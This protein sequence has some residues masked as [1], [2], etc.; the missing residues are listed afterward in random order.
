MIRQ[1]VHSHNF[2]IHPRLMLLQV[3]NFI[4]NN[5]CIKFQKLM[6]LGAKQIIQTYLFIKRQN[7]HIQLDAWDSV[8]RTFYSQLQGPM[9][10]LRTKVKDSFPGH[11]FLLSDRKINL[12]ITLYIH[13]KM[14]N[15]TA[16][17]Y[18]LHERMIREHQLVKQ[19]GQM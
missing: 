18:R 3:L 19:M 11:Y 5:T 8:S 12:K 17:N 9:K 16:G 14:K 6:H 7:K 13:E 15:N 1:R 2:N 10:I 4:H